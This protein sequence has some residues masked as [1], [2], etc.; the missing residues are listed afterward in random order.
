MQPVESVAFKVNVAGV[1]LFGVPE[2]TPVVG[3]SV[4]HVGNAPELSA[5]V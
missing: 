3:L 5:K 2:S 4:A 1:V